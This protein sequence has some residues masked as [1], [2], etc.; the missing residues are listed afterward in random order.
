M[1]TVPQAAMPGTTPGLPGSRTCSQLARTSDPCGLSLLPPPRQAP[2]G[3][4]PSLL[5]GVP[6]HPSLPAPG[7]HLTLQGPRLP[8]SGTFCSWE[9]TVGAPRPLPAWPCLASPGAQRGGELDPQGGPGADA[10]LS[11]PRTWLPSPSPT[12]VFRGLRGPS[13]FLLG[14]SLPHQR[15]HLPAPPA[16]GQSGSTSLSVS[17]CARLVLSVWGTEEE[18]PH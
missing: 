3:G 18:G 5:P 7:T 6:S 8:I 15:L 4:G 12:P 2:E 11:H 1:P 13:S 17:P 10:P 14:D 9:T 16:G